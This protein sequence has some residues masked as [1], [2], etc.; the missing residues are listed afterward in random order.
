MAVSCEEARHSLDLLINAKQGKRK[1]APQTSARLAVL[2]TGADVDREA[3]IL[4]AQLAEAREAE[5]HVLYVVLIPRDLPLT[6]PMPREESQAAVAIDKARSVLEKQGHSVP[7]IERGRDLASTIESF[8]IA[9]K[10][11]MIVLPVATSSQDLENQSKVFKTLLTRLPQE[12]IFV[13]SP[14]ASKL[15]I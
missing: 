9:I 4:A 7:H 13:K 5:V 6:A 2:L 8:L 10:G 15:A 1:A 3:L 11:S 12:V 14:T